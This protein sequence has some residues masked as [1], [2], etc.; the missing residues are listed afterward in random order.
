MNAVRH[1]SGGIFVLY[2]RTDKSY[3]SFINSFIK[4]VEKWLEQIKK[5]LQNRKF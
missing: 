1:M 4:E 5:Q 3:D 2:K